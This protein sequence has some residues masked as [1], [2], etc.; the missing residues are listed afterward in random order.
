MNMAITMQTAAR[1]AR[2]ARTVKTQRNAL[3]RKRLNESIEVPFPTLPINDIS[4]S[5]N[6]KVFS[7]I[8]KS[9]GVWVEIGM[10]DQALMAGGRTCTRCALKDSPGGTETQGSFEAVMSSGDVT[11]PS[12]RATANAR[13]AR[14]NARIA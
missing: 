12:A 4:L 9:A 7:C 14:Q 5:I 2:P 13:A 8:D 1:T 10:R 3:G 6:S 11:R